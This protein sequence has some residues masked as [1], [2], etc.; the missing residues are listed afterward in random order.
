MDTEGQVA[1]QRPWSCCPGNDAHLRVIIQW[2]IDN[3]WDEGEREGGREGRGGGREGGREGRREEE[4]EEKG[5]REGGRKDKVK[6]R[7]CACKSGTQTER[8]K[9]S[10]SLPNS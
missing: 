4:R 1:R 10:T 3:D 6:E 5:G 8:G 2:E 9:Q 7:G